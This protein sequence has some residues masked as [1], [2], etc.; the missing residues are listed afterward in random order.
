MLIDSTGLEAQGFGSAEEF[1][2]SGHLADSSCLILDVMLPGKSGIDLQAQLNDMGFRIP[3]IF[4]SAH[5]HEEA[6]AQAFE[7]GAVDFLHKPFSEEALL[8]GVRL[9]LKH[10]PEN[11]KRPKAGDTP[12]VD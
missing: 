9:A 2:D 4:I 5:D 3:I 1:M 7:A 12:A 6:R 11:C 10:M 8:N